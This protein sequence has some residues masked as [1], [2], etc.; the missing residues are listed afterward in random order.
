MAT[1]ILRVNHLNLLDLRSFGS[2]RQM[3]FQDYL[4][5]TAFSIH[6]RRLNTHKGREQLK[7]HLFCYSSGINAKRNTKF[8][9]ATRLLIE[10]SRV[11]EKLTNSIICIRTLGRC[12]C[13][14]CWI[15]CITTD[16]RIK[17]Q[18]IRLMVISVDGTGVIAICLIVHVHEWAI[19]ERFELATRSFL[20]KKKEN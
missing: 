11:D 5:S 13:I 7:I 6:W 14:C 18:M 12:W 20:M 15:I 19:I 3:E 9:N 16:G 8:I 17:I 1:V 10:G 2:F 4:W